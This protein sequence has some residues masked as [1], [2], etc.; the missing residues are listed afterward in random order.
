MQLMLE[1]E[2]KILLQMHNLDA[3]CC[4]EVMLDAFLKVATE[5]KLTQSMSTLEKFY[6]DVWDP[7]SIYYNEFQS[8]FLSFLEKK[9]NFETSL[10]KP[11]IVNG[12]SRDNVSILKIGSIHKIK[13]TIG[14]ISKYFIL[15][16]GA[17]YCMVSFKYAAEL[18]EN[19]YLDAESDYLGDMDLLL[20][21]G[22]TVPSALYKMNGVKVGEFTL[23]NIVFALIEED[24][25][26]LFGMNILNAFKS[27]TINSN[28]SILELVK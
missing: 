12:P 24:T 28:A 25:N 16:S 13:V 5:H 4:A 9:C 26:L 20:A 18:V 23:D 19:G 2:F 6:E 3:D 22:R 1:P 17:S 11:K 15:Y 21:D 7:N 8:H 10:L 14:N 27:A